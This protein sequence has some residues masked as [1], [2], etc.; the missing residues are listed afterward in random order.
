[1]FVIEVGILDVKPTQQLSTFS[2]IF[3][4]QGIIVDSKI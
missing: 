3:G 4:S 1:M 2:T